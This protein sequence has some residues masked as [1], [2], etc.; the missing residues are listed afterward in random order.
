MIIFET[1]R[2]TVRQYSY[3]L[4]QENIFRVNGDIDVM[5]YIRPV[6]TKEECES[7]LIEEIEAYKKFP[8]AG[9]WAVD[10]KSSGRFVGSFAFIPVKDTQHMQLGYALLKEN[11]GKGF[12]TE[13]MKE[14]IKYVFVKTSL[15]EIYGTTESANITSQKV[16]LKTGFSLE[17][18]YT[19][20]GKEISQFILRRESI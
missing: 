15:Q 4:D 7:F 12:A 9:R 10:E 6:K 17:K 1:E 3:E 16:L 8:E 18:T 20:G 19:E 5:R 11:W 14:G 13:L 2:L